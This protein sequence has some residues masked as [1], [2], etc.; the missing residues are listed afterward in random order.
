MVKKSHPIEKKLRLQ[1]YITL[2]IYT[3]VGYALVVVADY[4]FSQFSNPFFAWLHWRIDLIYFLYLVIGYGC[5]FYHYWGKPWGYLQEIIDATKTV[6]QQ[7]DSTI[8]LPEPLKDMEKQMNKI[9]MSVL[10]SQQAVKEAERKKNELVMYLAHDIRTPLTSVIGY[11][12]LLDEAPDMAVEQKA[13]YVGIALEKLINE[14]FEIT[15]YNTQQI[16]IIKEN[17]DL[18]YMLV[19]WLWDRRL[20]CIPNRY[21]LFVRGRHHAVTA[22]CSRSFYPT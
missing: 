11:L 15:R 21:F 12:S 2:L 16:K 14:F 3:L 8:E 10:L 17:V 18:Y 9:K 13:K 4:A 1:L 22:G 5:I 20:L 7:N 19:R 6:Y